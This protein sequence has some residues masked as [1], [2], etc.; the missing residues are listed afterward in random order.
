MIDEEKLKRLKRINE[1]QKRHKLRELYEELRVVWRAWRQAKWV[2][3]EKPIPNGY[4]KYFVLRDDIARRSDSDT[5]SKILKVINDHIYC[6][7]VD[8]KITRNI[9]KLERNPKTKRL[10][11]KQRMIE[12]D[13]PHELRVISRLEWN[14][15]NWPESYK[16]WFTYTNQTYFTSYGFSYVKEGYRFNFPYYFVPKISQH[17]ITRVRLL[18]EEAEYK[19]KLLWNKINR[20]NLWPKIVHMVSGSY[21]R[22]KDEWYRPVHV[23]RRLARPSQQ[24]YDLATEA[25]DE[26]QLLLESRLQRQYL[27]HTYQIYEEPWDDPEYVFEKS[28]NQEI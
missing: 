19:E 18:D 1:K 25:K 2:D 6:R 10:F 9:K 4:V 7:D 17:F 12:Q 28:T 16:K 15:L 22:N 3:L 27:A 26:L 20:D 21:G 13:I 24:K 5:F 14:E 8:F 23:Q 11:R